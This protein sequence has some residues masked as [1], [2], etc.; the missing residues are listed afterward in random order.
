MA[1]P[2]FW[3]DQAAAQAVV[4]QISEHKRTIEAWAEVQEKYE[5]AETI[6]ELVSEE[7]D[8]AL[9]QELEQALEELTEDVGRLEL[10][11]LL[12]GEYDGNNALVSIHPGAGGTESQDWAAMLLRM[13]TRWAE[14]R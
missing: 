1:E 11:A 14:S 5:D 2:G 10:T 6:L 12:N 13:Y 7:D 9:E 8:E 4:K 3:D